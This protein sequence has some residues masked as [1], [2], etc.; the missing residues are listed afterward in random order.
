MIAEMG[1]AVGWRAPL[2]RLAAAEH[3][4][5]IVTGPSTPPIL[6]EASAALAARLARGSAVEVRTG[7][8][9]PH[10]DAPRTLAALAL[11]LT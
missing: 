10:V 9:P 5:A 3:P 11:E 2:P 6:R 8:A 7:G 1:I 4:S